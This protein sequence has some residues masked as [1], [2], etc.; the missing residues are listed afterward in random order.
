MTAVGRTVKPYHGPMRWIAMLMWGGLGLAGL[1]ACGG[2]EDRPE[3][4]A[5]S[6]SPAVSA[7]ALPAERGVAE[8]ARSAGAGP[9]L[10]P[11]ATQLRREPAI[12]V[13]VE[14]GATEVILTA[15]ATLRVAGPRGGPAP[16]KVYPFAAPLQVRR[17]TVEGGGA[18]ELRDP[19][20]RV[21]RWRLPELLIECDQ[22]GAIGLG[23]RAYPR[24]LVLSPQTDEAGGESGRFDVVNHVPMETY[25]AGVIER[26]LYGSWP[27]ETF[28]AQ[29]VA[30]RSYAAWEQTIARDRAYD[31][32]STTASQAYVGQAKNA[33]AV[34]AVAETRGE[35]LV[36]AGRVVPAFYSSSTGGTGQDAVLAFPN[37]VENI[38]PLRAREQGAWDRDSPQWRWGPVQRNNA[39]L[40]RR[41]AAWGRDRP[42]P[43]AQLSQLRRI[44]VAGRNAIGRPS[45][46]RVVG[47]DQRGRAAEYTLDAESLR[48]ACNDSDDDRLPLPKGDRLLSSHLEVAVGA[49]H[50][51]F[52]GR[53]YGHGVGLS[54]WGARTMGQ[55]GHG[56]R[57][58]LDFYYPGAE[59][60]KLY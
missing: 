31:L 51:T 11:P 8:A 40:A 23:E 54:Q 56:Y 2:C 53:G 46:Y 22:G 49:T 19:A 52:R 7:V 17:V 45:V 41:L 14:A 55:A 4:A 25:L 29:A 24:R 33:T 15:A 39:T 35:F 44:E 13:R 26:E 3:S 58:I 36:Y 38:P 37:R 18:W 9:Y 34:R 30:A 43:I 1:V 27:L 12:R 48:I 10:G 42:H 50:T 60:K 47:V 16:S 28:K 57:A 21:V 20:G 32:E 5:G 6:A 59:V